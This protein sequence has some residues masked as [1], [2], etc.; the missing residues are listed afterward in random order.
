LTHFGLSRAHSG[1]SQE[2]GPPPVEAAGQPMAIDGM[3]ARDVIVDV[4][5]I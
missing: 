1:S 4:M 5:D 3:Q 2:A